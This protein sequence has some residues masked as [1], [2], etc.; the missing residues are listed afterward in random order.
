MDYNK[1]SVD[2]LWQ[3]H[4]LYIRK[5]CTYKLKSTPSERKILIHICKAKD[6]VIPM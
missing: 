3:K 4:E 6:R 2:E 5:L 1:K